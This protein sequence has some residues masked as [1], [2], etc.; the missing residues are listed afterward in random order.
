MFQELENCQSSSIKQEA[1]QPDREI[2][3]AVIL[4]NVTSL[5]SH[6]HGYV[7]RDNGPGSRVTRLAAHLVLVFRIFE[8]ARDE[9]RKMGDD[10]IKAYIKVILHTYY[11]MT[12]T[13]CHS[14]SLGSGT[15]CGIL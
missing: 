3:Q 11:H 12:V 7:T 13:V 4:D 9:T 15:I 1:H 2:Q 5:M 6:L 14:V 8:Q 10:I